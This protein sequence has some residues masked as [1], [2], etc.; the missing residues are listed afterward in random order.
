[1]PF[2][3]SGCSHPP[4]EECPVIQATSSASA[5]ITFTLCRLGRSRAA[6]ADVAH[7]QGSREFLVRTNGKARD[8]TLYC[9][10]H[11][12]MTRYGVFS[13]GQ[14]PPVLWR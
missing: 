3:W 7:A 13:A 2:L 14:D 8:K 5:R 1:M 12:D 6:A 10:Q 9:L 11:S 4:I